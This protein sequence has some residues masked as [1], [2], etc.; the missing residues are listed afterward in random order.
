MTITLNGS[1]NFTTSGIVDAG[2]VN[3]LAFLLY[4]GYAGIPG[5]I[6]EISPGD[7]LAGSNLFPAAVSAYSAW[8]GISNGVSGEDANNSAANYLSTSAMSGTWRCLGH[9]TSW[10]TVSNYGFP[11]TVW[12]RTA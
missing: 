9:A 4:A 2:A 11:I 1:D 7:T 10:E 8:S 12:V 6:A 5:E 3:S